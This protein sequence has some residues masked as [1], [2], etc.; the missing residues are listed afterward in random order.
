[1]TGM[2]SRSIRSFR[3]QSASKALSIARQCI[4]PGSALKMQEGGDKCPAD[5]PPIKAAVSRRSWA[6]LTGDGL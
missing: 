1:M 6:C 2:I 4:E 3:N 5:R